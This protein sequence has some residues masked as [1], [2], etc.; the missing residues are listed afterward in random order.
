V[1][2][3]LSEETGQRIVE[4]LEE[5]VGKHE[6]DERPVELPPGCGRLRA[7]RSRARSSAPASPASEVT[8]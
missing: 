7:Y 3:P 4:L 2:A 6:E 8:P 1:S 5:L